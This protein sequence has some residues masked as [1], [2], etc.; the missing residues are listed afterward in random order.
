MS[1]DIVPKRIRKSPDEIRRT[2][3][4]TLLQFMEARG[5]IVGTADEWFDEVL[6]S[7]TEDGVYRLWLVREAPTGSESS[8]DEVQRKAKGKACLVKFVEDATSTTTGNTS[9]V[10]FMQQNKGKRKI[11][12][13]PNYMRK[14]CQ[15][16]MTFG[17][18]EVFFEADL[19][20]NILTNPLQPK[21]EVLT[22]AEAARVR[23]EYV[24]QPSRISP[25]YEFDPVAI[26]LG[27]KHTDML[28]IITANEGSGYIAIYRI[29][30]RTAAGRC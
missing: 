2:A 28:R 7:G 18:V 3:V 1:T 4:L 13:I 21:F 5:K 8:P 17:D 30:V 14:L 22:R 6:S 19:L 10:N 26:A 29:V 20:D 11:V 15:N 16:L 23:K 12:V 24:L 9:L 25:L 27:L